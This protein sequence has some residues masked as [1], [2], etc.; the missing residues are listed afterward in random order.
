[1]CCS[2]LWLKIAPCNVSG[3]VALCDVFDP[4]IYISP[5]GAGI[6]VSPKP[7]RPSMSSMYDFD[8]DDVPEDFEFGFDISNEFFAEDVHLLNAVHAGKPSISRSSS[9]RE[10]FGQAARC[11]VFDSGIVVPLAGKFSPHAGSSALVDLWSSL[12][13][14]SSKLLSQSL[15]GDTFPKLR[16]RTQITLSSTHNSFLVCFWGGHS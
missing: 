13:S 3:Q 2:R 5:P 7:S 10:V 15:L 4:G 6:V 8:D 1:M 16:P 11:D 9:H 12:L 14:P